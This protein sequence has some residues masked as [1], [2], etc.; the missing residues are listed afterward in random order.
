MSEDPRFFIIGVSCHDET[1]EWAAKVFELRKH[2]GSNNSLPPIMAQ[3]V[4]SS[5][6]CVLNW[7]LALG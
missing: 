2:S 5:K 6:S 7:T 3:S 1:A 4:E